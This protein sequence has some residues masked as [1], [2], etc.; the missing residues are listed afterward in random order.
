MRCLLPLQISAETF[1][2]DSWL[3]HLHQHARVTRTDRLLE[4]A[5]RP[6]QIGEQ[7]KTTHLIAVPPD[8]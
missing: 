5:L 8:D 6:F 2:T 3:E 4:Q 7:P 1:L